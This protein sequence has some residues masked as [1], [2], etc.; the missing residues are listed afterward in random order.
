[1]TLKPE[2]IDFDNEWFH[3]KQTIDKV[4]NIK[5][6]D[7]REWTERFSNIYRIC[8][9]TPEP[10]WQRLYFETQNF[11]D[12]YVANLFKEFENLP[13]NEFLKGYYIKW[14]NYKKGL[15]NLL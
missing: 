3:L 15:Y 9:A 5:E 12:D 10:L 4:I 6:I 7:R 2:E 13:N 8:V 11:L 1:M 14:D